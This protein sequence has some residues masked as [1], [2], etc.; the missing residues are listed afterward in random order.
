M[1]FTVFHV[2]LALKWETEYWVFPRTRCI[3]RDE[4]IDVL[5]LFT[6]SMYQE[7]HKFF[8]TQ[9]THTM[10]AAFIALN[11]TSAR[12]DDQENIISTEIAMAAFGIVRGRVRELCDVH[13]AKTRA[14]GKGNAAAWLFGGR[15]RDGIS[16][17]YEWAMLRIVA[18][19]DSVRGT[20]NISRRGRD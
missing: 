1:Y 5:R 3:D 6:E 11:S 12:V 19:E 9:K 7:M 20:G 16:T 2:E 18:M 10:S 8:M 14:K 15:Q 4:E 13:S 17:E